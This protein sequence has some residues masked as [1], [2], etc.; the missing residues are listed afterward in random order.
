MTLLM[1]QN[2]YLVS[3]PK[4]PTKKTNN[5]VKKMDGFFNNIDIICT[6]GMIKDTVVT[7]LI[8]LFFIFF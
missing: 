5:F 7:M 2:K 8:F 4:I 6:V 3:V 1:F